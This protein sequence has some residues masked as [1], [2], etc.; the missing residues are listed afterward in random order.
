MKSE[1][2]DIN[3][4][5]NLSSQLKNITEELEDSTNQLNSILKRANNY[6]GIDITTPRKILRN[7]LKNVSADMKNVSKNIKGYINGINTLNQ[8]DISDQV[9][10]LSLNN[11]ANKIEDFLTYMF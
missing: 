9:N 8:D 6:D 7:N 1:I 2:N 10:L 11:I 4:L 3:E 5:T